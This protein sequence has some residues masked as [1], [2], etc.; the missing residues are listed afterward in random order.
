M[1]RLN[2]LKNSHKQRNILLRSQKDIT[3][4]N[5]Y[6]VDSKCDIQQNDS[7]NTFLKIPQKKHFLLKHFKLSIKNQLTFFRSIVVS[8]SNQLIKFIQFK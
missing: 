4:K 2:M 1:P 7:A 5:N 6:S 3:I 8:L